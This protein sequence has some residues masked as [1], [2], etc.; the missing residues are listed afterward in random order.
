MFKLI[1]ENAK[2]EQLTLSNNK[3]YIISDIDGLTPAAANINSSVIGLGDGELF[4]S[5]R[6]E[7][8]SLSLSIMPRGDVEKNRIK[9]YKFFKP[10][11]YVKI[12]YANSSRDV[13]IEGYVE[14]FEGNFFT[15]KEVMEIGILCLQPYFKSAEEIV[16]DL[17]NIL[18][19]F[20]FPFAI[21]AAGIPFSEIIRVEYENIYNGGDVESGVI[22]ELQAEGDVVNPIIYD[23]ISSSLGFKITL[24]AGD[25]IRV[26]TYKGSKSAVLIQNGLETNILNKLM[27]NPTWFRL[28]PG[29]NLLSYSC[30]SGADALQVRFYH[31]DLYEGV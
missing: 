30:D 15:D 23:S 24:A 18:G 13:F 5:S 17:S 26:N 10:K 2:G 21:N 6:V 12:Y 27:P 22:I 16:T 7:K 3:N 25:V 28:D 1:V 4:E 20:S 9:L 31:Y 8:R 14:S 11:H 29:D 19:G